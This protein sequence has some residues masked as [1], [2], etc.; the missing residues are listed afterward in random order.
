MRCHQVA[1]RS[2]AILMPAIRLLLVDH[3]E[4]VRDALV[5]RLEREP[6]LVVVDAV[7][8]AQ[9]ALAAYDGDRHDLVVTEHLL[10]DMTGIAL[11]GAL[12]DRDPGLRA[13]LLTSAEDRR[14]VVDAIRGG[15]D[16]IVRKRWATGVLVGAVRA[17]AD[18][19]CV[20]DRTALD[21]IG[22]C[23]TAAA[24]G[25]DD[26][27]GQDG[28]RLSPREVEVLACLAEGLTNAQIGAR[29]FVSRETVKTH[30]ANLLRKLAVD[31][32]SAAAT[33]AARLGILG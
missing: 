5:V 7:G 14:L 6:D 15:I 30:V 16:G 8:T 13:V 22:A 3:H 12:R 33:K 4:L 27:C 9:E 17:V 10:P 19:A 1:G 21:E 11:V 24:T 25:E 28:G 18:G 23:L 32:R 2:E 20:L 29:L 26:A 31:D